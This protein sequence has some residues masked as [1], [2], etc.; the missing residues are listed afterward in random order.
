MDISAQ[1]H[2]SYSVRF[3][4]VRNAFSNSNPVRNLFPPGTMFKGLGKEDF[5]QCLVNDDDDQNCN[6]L[7]KLQEA[8]I[9]CVF[10]ILL[11]LYVSVYA[12][13]NSSPRSGTPSVT[14]SSPSPSYLRLVCPPPPPPSVSACGRSLSL[15]LSSY[16]ATQTF[17]GQS[18]KLLLSLE[19]GAKGANK[20]ASWPPAV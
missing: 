9:F 12:G 11:F 14:Q 3:G 7:L 13:T 5:F 4:I 17:V 2:G 1:L 15:S 6:F 20:I 10:V 18:S 19:G 8:I 16:T